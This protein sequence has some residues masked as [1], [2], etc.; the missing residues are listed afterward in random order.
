MKLLLFCLYTRQWKDSGRR[1]Q[2]DYILGPKM[3]SSM[4]YIHSKVKLCSTWDHHPLYA[5]V[6]EDDRQG[7]FAQQK[8]EDGM[9]RMDAV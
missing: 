6:S 3:D 2:L 9:G 5:T 8:K 4:T 7:Y 1:S